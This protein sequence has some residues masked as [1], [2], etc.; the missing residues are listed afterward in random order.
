MIV[1]EGAATWM[2]GRCPNQEPVGPEGPRHQPRLEPQANAPLA[3]HRPRPP[4][5]QSYGAGAA[6]TSV[7]Q[8]SPPLSASHRT[9]E[10]WGFWENEVSGRDE[11]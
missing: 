11:E 6:L 9:Y 1:A 3:H 5:A 10:C 8:G 7:S 2:G 4:L